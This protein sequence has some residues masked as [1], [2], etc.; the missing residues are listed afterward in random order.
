MKLLRAIAEVGG[1]IVI[2]V[3]IVIA[4]N[5]YFPIHAGDNA[6]KVWV[7]GGVATLGRTPKEIDDDYK[8]CIDMASRTG[9]E[10]NICEPMM[11]VF[12]DR[13][14]RKVTIEGFFLDRDELNIRGFP[15]SVPY[16]FAEQYCKEIGGF[17]P[18]E[19]QWEW[20]ARRDTIWPWGNNSPTK[21]E[22]LVDIEG[23]NP[24]QEPKRVDS[25][26]E[27]NGLRNMVGNLAEWVHGGIKKGGGSGT[28]SI[29]AK[30]SHAI[31]GSTT[32]AGFRC[33]YLTQPH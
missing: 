29:F 5:R 7:D 2:A 3:I 22:T 32:P 12:G 11:E 18:S 16:S 24:K 33:A 26:P 27:Y 13:P 14:E 20:A 1:A 25:Y 6:E 9:Q 21:D 30:P 19:D 8:D 4:I 17:L 10:L 23:G 15:V 31:S 28:Y